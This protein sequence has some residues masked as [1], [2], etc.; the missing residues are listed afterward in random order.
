MTM[1]LNS[2]GNYTDYTELRYIVCKYVVKNNP[3]TNSY[4]IKTNTSGN[5][6]KK[7]FDVKRYINKN[8]F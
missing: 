1:F 5:I 3:G 6:T 4:C 8:T 7:D 2:T